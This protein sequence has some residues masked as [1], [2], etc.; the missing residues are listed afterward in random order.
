L[1]KEA[2]FR[3]IRWP[4]MRLL[5]N[6]LTDREGICDRH[7]LCCWMQK[8]RTMILKRRYSRSPRRK[9]RRMSM[10]LAIGIM[11]PVIVRPVRVVM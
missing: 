1:L 7:K 5:E 3:N 11:L 2:V 8:N 4:S 9:A 10:L 6:I